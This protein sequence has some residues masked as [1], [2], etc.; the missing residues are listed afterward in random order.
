MSE[1]GQNAFALCAQCVCLGL[2]HHA[3]NKL[4]VAGNCRM[5][6]SFDFNH[7]QS[8]SAGGLQAFIM[9]KRRHCDAK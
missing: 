3:V 8:A 4:R 2:D 9:T 1:Q 6:P 5:G 7:A